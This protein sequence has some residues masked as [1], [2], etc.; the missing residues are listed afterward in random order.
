MIYLQI[1][2][3]HHVL[4]YNS[5]THD[6]LITYLYIVYKSYHDHILQGGAP[7]L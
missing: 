1:G 5:Y 4:M 7:Q 2:K 6:M 3:K